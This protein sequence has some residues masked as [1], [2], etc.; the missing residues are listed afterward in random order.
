MSDP[1]DLTLSNPLDPEAVVSWEVGDRV[2]CAPGTRWGGKDISGQVLEVVHVE[3]FPGQRRRDVADWAVA[4]D[5]DPD[6]ATSVGA[7]GDRLT[8][9]QSAANCQTVA[10][11]WTHQPG[12]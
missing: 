1:I 11:P 3:P 4:G 8:R 10:L 5:D 2:T 7:L 9:A 6:E 12:A